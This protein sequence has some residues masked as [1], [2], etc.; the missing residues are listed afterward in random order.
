M[1]AASIVDLYRRLTDRGIAL[2]LDGGWG[3]DALLGEQTRPHDDL[4]IVI[5]ER[6]V[7]GVRELLESEGFRDVARDDTSAWNFVLGHDDS[8]LVDVHVVVFDDAGNGV[9]GPPRHGG[10]YPA[11]AFAGVGTVNGIPV[12]CLTAEYQLRSRNYMLRN[13]DIKDA[14]ALRAR[15]ATKPP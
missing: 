12:R 15:F 13:K 1:N 9:Y 3:V 7:L 14:Q 5:G 10:I 8:R 6:H 4:D 2:W 11:S